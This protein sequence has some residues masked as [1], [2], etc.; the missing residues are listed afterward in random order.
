MK[1]IVGLG[2]PGRQYENSRH[3]VGFRVVEE[4]AR[5]WRIDIARRAFSG[6]LG[7]GRIQERPVVLLQPATYMN[8]SGRS[9]R[10]AVTFYKLEL[11]DL[12]VVVDD[13]ALP[14]GR[15]RLR[16]RGSSG[17]HKGLTSVINELGSETFARLRVGIDRAEEGSAVSHVLGSFSADEGER[18]GRVIPRAADAAEC[19]LT[20]GVENAM[21]KFNCPEER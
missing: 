8:L 1:L 4:L 21:N 20:D 18:I 10:E 5:R 3:N 9:V 16:A 12:L 15:L 13:L 14:I 17:G 2:N 19:W 6:N 7:R 11:E